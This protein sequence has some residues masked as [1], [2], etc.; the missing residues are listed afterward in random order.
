MT[1][2]VNG[3]PN[4][5]VLF[6]VVT[7]NSFSTLKLSQDVSETTASATK[8]QFKRDFVDRSIDFF[9]SVHITAG[10]FAAS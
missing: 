5:R 9:F 7:Y 2:I 6:V 10:G 3:S 8:T 4:V 1:R